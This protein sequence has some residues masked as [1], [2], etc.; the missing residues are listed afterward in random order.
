LDNILKFLNDNKI[1]NLTSESDLL[2]L[3]SLV[4]PTDKSVLENAR[5]YLDGLM[6]PPKSLG[7]LEEIAA[8]LVCVTGNDKLEINKKCVS[9][10]CADNGV[11]CEGIATAPQ[12]VTVFMARNFTKS[13]TGVC[14]LAKDAGADINIVDVGMKEDVDHPLIKNMKVGYGTKNFRKEKSMTRDEAVKSVI[15]GIMSVVEL[16]LMGYDII[17][18]GEMGIGN[19]TTASAVLSAVTG[20]SAAE[21]VGK[22]AGLSDEG[23]N[24][25]KSVITEALAKYNPDKNDILDII[26]CVG[27]FDIAAM[28]G[29]YIGAAFSQMPV[30]VDGFISAAAALCAVKM[31]PN[32]LDYMFLSHCSEEKGY[33]A[34]MS[35]LKMEAPLNLHMR[36]GEGSG[37]PLMFKIMDSALAVYRNMGTFADGNISEEYVEKV[38]D[39]S[40]F[41]V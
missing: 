20:L 7:L 11:V 37:C 35:A 10:Y 16:K 8:K 19:T 32:V 1:A 39:E 9:L 28:A 40:S 26:S 4:K 15:N 14:A 12:E 31:C 30:V 27:G 3:I 24:K 6:K 13:L 38:Q 5:S 41:K 22:G 29:A 36:L 33:L 2:N 17:G 34:I 18:V 21:T 23:Y 25:K